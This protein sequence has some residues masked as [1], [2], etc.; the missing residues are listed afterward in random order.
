MSA[1]LQISISHCKSGRASYSGYCSLF[2]ISFPHTLHR[3]W[4]LPGKKRGD[5]NPV[6]LVDVTPTRRKAA[7]GQFSSCKSYSSS[8]CSCSSHQAK[9]FIIGSFHRKL[10]TFSFR[11]V[12]PQILPGQETLTFGQPYYPTLT[13]IGLILHLGSYTM[14]C[15]IPF[16]CSGSQGWVPLAAVETNHYSSVTKIKSW[17]KLCTIHTYKLW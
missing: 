16:C 3:H 14:L 11:T 4:F 10:W 13:P 7:L 15:S 2:P 17:K 12:C 9:L 1:V 8:L 6:R 5:Y